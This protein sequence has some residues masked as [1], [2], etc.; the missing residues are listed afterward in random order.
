L[1]NEAKNANHWI[2]IRLVG[3]NSNRSAIG[4]R[5]SVR[6]ANRRWVDEVRSGSS[7]S[8]SNDLRL[9]FGLGTLTAVQGIEVRWPNGA[10]EQFM[11]DGVDRI[12]E[13]VEGK[14]QQSGTK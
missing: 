8:S 10:R 7:Y 12:L 6:A 5:V 4:A 9:H 3:T 14:G 13:L 2:G 11:A 1:V